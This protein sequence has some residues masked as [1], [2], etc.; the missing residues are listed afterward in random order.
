VKLPARSAAAR[1][2]AVARR[3]GDGATWSICR[4]CRWPT[5]PR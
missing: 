4:P 3:T 2:I 5:A 1:A